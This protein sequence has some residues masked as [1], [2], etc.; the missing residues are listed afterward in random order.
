M[1]EVGVPPTTLFKVYLIQDGVR[2]V[3]VG[4]SYDNISAVTIACAIYTTLE[5]MYPDSH[6]AVGVYDSMDTGVAFV[7]EHAGG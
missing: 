2:G 7:G 4:G 3:W 6:N 5:A 1:P